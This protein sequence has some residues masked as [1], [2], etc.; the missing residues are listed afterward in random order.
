M[1]HSAA[2]VVRSCN[3]LRE[4]ALPPVGLG[5][6]ARGRQPRPRLHLLGNVVV[7]VTPFPRRR[8]GIAQFQN[9]SLVTVVLQRVTHRFCITLPAP[10]T[11]STSRNMPASQMH[12]TGM[13]KLAKYCATKSHLQRECGLSVS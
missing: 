9:V 10:V 13:E 2:T 7:P 1:R 5:G 4:D 3:V 11:V 6:D 12:L 8:E